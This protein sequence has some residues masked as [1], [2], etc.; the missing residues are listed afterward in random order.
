M[1]YSP[2]NLRIISCSL[3]ITCFDVFS[4]INFFYIQIDHK[5]YYEETVFLH[6]ATNQDYIPLYQDIM[7]RQYDKISRIQYDFVVIS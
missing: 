1:R 5:I 3:K 6:V 4:F 2:E 7:L